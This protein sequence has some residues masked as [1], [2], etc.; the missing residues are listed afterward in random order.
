MNSDQSV[1]LSVGWVWCRRGTHSTW[2]WRPPDY[3]I[4]LM[5]KRIGTDRMDPGLSALSACKRRMKSIFHIYFF[6]FLQVQSLVVKMH[7]LK[8]MLCKRQ[9][10]RINQVYRMGKKPGKKRKQTERFQMSL[11]RTVWSWLPVT[12]R[13]AAARSTVI[14]FWWAHCTEWV[15]RQQMTSSLL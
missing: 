8:N 1:Y 2:P 12:T 11:T 13:P 9:R 4:Q 15:S 14:G 6:L 10:E 5:G 3:H 7:L